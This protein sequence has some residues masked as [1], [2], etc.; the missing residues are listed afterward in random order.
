MG[1]S[2]S[3]GGSGKRTGGNSVPR[4]GPTQRGVLVVAS[5][6]AVL[7][8]DDPCLVGEDP[9]A[10]LPHSRGDRGQNILGLPPAL[11]MHDEVVGKTLK[12]A[13]REF[14]GHPRIERV[15]H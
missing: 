3:A 8:V 6:P 10:H 12:R 11:A 13:A 5:T 7:A 1:K 9:Q 14:P 15:M 4:P 2:G